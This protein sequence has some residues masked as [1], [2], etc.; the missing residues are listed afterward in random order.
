MRET[1]QLGSNTTWT[2]D[3]SI[4]GD[5][6]MAGKLAGRIEVQG[7]LTIVSGTEVKG[8]IESNALVIAPGAICQCSVEVR[9]PVVKRKK[10]NLFRLRLV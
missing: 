1:N 6:V 4:Q 5:T 8:A 3:L 7:K 9:R 10:M 2:G